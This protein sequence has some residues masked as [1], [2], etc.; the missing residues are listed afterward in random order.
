MNERL[1]TTKELT[2]LI[3]GTTVSYW[4]GLRFKSEG[5]KYLKP[6]PRKVLYL[7]S[8]VWEWLRNT[9]RSGTVEVA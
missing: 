3:P 8:Q 7:E 9:E 4:A 6:S 5:P 2:E 1:L